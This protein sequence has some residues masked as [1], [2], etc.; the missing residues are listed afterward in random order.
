MR[1]VFEWCVL[2]EAGAAEAVEEET[3]AGAQPTLP[4]LSLFPT[5]VDATP[6]HHPPPP[7]Q[8]LAPW[9]MFSETDLPAPT[10]R[11]ASAPRKGGWCTVRKS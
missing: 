11:G 1:R 9:T 7:P 5:A 6:P 2:M 8:L 3:A 4:P 10:A